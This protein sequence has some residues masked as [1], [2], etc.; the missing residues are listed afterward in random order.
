LHKLHDASFRLS[1]QLTLDGVQPSAGPAWSLG[2][3]LRWL[4]LELIEFAVGD[5]TP[6]QPMRPDVAAA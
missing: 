6:G 4:D 5:D 2:R 1:A 3:V